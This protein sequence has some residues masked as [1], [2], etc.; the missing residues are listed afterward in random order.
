MM[1][2]LIYSTAPNGRLTGL[3]IVES[4]TRPH[5]PTF[6][7]GFNS[8]EEALA[9][10][11]EYLAIDQQGYIGVNEERVNHTVTMFERLRRSYLIAPI[12][13]WLVLASLILSVINA[14]LT[15]AHIAGV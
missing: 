7:G 15:I 13:L 3:R 2:W 6:N 1:H 5:A 14:A 11:Q 9:L 12:V 8:P 10:M 4:A